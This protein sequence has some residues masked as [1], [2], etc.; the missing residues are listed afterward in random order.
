MPDFTTA[1]QSHNNEIPPRFRNLPAPVQQVLEQE[2]GWAKRNGVPIAD[3]G[4]PR[5]GRGAL[6]RRIALATIDAKP[7]YA[8]MT[9]LCDG[10]VINL[11]GSGPAHRT[12][13]L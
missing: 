9:E 12:G 13:E 8:A 3:D 5:Y 4:L 11:N 1:P 10:R 6:A 2:I 7:H